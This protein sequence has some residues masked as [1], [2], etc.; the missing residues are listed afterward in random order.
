MNA[1]NSDAG[2]LKE[3]TVTC[4]S[5]GSTSLERLDRHEYKCSNCGSIT[6]VSDAE[7]DRLEAVLVKLLGNADLRGQT[8]VWSTSSE[9]L[10][11]PKPPAR[12]QTQSSSGWTARGVS[13]VFWFVGLIVLYAVAFESSPAAPPPSAIPTVPAR[14][15]TLTQRE[16]IGNAEIGLLTNTSQHPVD[17]P[18]M[19][20]TT[21]NG[22]FKIGTTPGTVGIKH[23]LPNEHTAAVFGTAANGEA[24]RFEF[25]VETD[26][27]VST[28]TVIPLQL[29]QQKLLHVVKSNNY[30][31]VGVLQNPTNTALPRGKIT[32]T[33][34]DA[35]H[36]I[37]GWGTGV[38]NAL[39]AAEKA[40]VSINLEMSADRGEIASYD[41]LIDV[42]PL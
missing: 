10:T 38:S 14:E 27:P 18:P 29:M 12:P 20:L 15:L 33:L 36:K 7:A 13:I 42:S 2:G 39:E 19:T 40:A 8:R 34:Y 41:Y 9:R 25:T 3:I 30:Q 11:P 28:A 31:L 6:V 26:A 16:T 21:Y 1:Q 4:N 32:V 24:T 22:D 37:I 17:L 5:C 23:L 35:D